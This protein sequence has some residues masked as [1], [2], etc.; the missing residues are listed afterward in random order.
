MLRFLLIAG[1][2]LLGLVFLI[3]KSYFDRKGYDRYKV[4]S[5]GLLFVVASILLALV[6]R[7]FIFISILVVIIYFALQRKR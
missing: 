3:P 2:L 5:V 7:F 1:I 6:N 4:Y